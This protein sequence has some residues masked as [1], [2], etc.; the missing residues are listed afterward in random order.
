[1]VFCAISRSLQ[2]V[3]GEV[4]DIMNRNDRPTLAHESL[5]DLSSEPF[6]LGD[7]ESPMLR[8]VSV[9]SP[10]P[11]VHDDEHNGNGQDVLRAVEEGIAGLAMS[12]GGLGHDPN[13]E[14]FPTNSEPGSS[15]TSE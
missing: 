14:A 10:S 6:S 11:N 2:P 3:L 4:I 9:S 13:V 15:S 12:D 8:L 7:P 5:P 1:M